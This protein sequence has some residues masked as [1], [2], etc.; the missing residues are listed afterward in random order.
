MASY[1]ENDVEANSDGGH[2]E[3][4]HSSGLDD[5]TTTNQG[6]DDTTIGTNR[7]FDIN[8]PRNRQLAAKEINAVRRTKYFVIICLLCIMIGVACGAYFLSAGSEQV[9]FVEQ[10]NEDAKKV[11]QTMGRNLIQTLQASDAFTVSITSLAMATNQTWPYVVVPDFAVRA[12]KI[13]S[14]AN[15][16]LVNTYYFVEPE[17]RSEWENFTARTGETWVNESIAAIEEFE[18]MD[19]PIVWDYTSY[20]VLFDYDEYDKENP[21]EVG[22]N[23]TGPWLPMWQTQPTIAYEPPYNWY[24]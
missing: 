13:R 10:F 8:N 24:V 6:E 4:T 20:D 1:V 11:L 21:G 22:T 17:Q 5:G 14:L 19:W 16:V 2:S 23:R 9:E 15:A 3:H 18:G 7:D 12:E